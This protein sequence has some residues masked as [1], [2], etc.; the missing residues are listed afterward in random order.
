MGKKSK[1]NEEQVTRIRA[2]MSER[3]SMSEKGRRRKEDYGRNSNRGGNQGF[4]SIRG[5]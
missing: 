4:F 1:K 2:K 3:G 5:T